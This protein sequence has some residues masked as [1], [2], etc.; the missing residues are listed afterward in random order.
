MTNLY[1]ERHERRSNLQQYSIVEFLKWHRQKELVLNPKFQRRPVWS[2]DA[3]TYLIDSILTGFPMP[4]VYLRSTIDKES[5]VAM[6]EVVDGQQ[7][8]RAIIEFGDNRLRLNNRS[9]DFRGMTFESLPEFAQDDFL[10][11]QISVEQLLNADDNVVLE[12]FARLNS[13]N[14]ALNAAELRHAKYETELK[15]FVSSL[16]SELRWFLDSFRILTPKTMVRM[17]DDAF[18]A[19]LVNIL[20][21]GVGDGGA[22]ALNVLY[23]NN[24]SSFPDELHFRSIIVGAVEWMAGNLADVIV[25]TLLRRPYQIQMLFAAY[26]HQTNGLPQGRLD[27]LPSRVGIDELDRVLYRLGR[28]A[29]A[30][31]SE[32]PEAGLEPFVEASTGA[33]TRLKSRS[34]RFAAFS[35]A[36]AR[37]E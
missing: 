30:L 1:I 9:R 6:R 15:W 22:A 5:L 31:E 26:V 7:R 13:Y 28:L 3:K 23:K 2:P 17:S 33:T 24:Q 18:F 20:K 11:Y 8:L 36:L 12:V 35:S 34:V 21:Y 32:E 27:E 14:L 37:R 29:D 4:K 25:D 16:S 10:S 19:E